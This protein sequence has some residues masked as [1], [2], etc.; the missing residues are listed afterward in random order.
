MPQILINYFSA[1]INLLLTANNKQ[2]FSANIK[3]LININKLFARK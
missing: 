1:I 2:L 3:L